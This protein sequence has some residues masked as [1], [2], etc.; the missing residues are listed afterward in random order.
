MIN[1]ISYQGISHSLMRRIQK[2]TC[3]VPR[4]IME[5]LFQQG[6]L[7]EISG[8]SRAGGIFILRNRQYYNSQTGIQIEGDDYYI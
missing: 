8:G 6:V 4:K 3:S 5:A 2:Y 1:Q 7:E